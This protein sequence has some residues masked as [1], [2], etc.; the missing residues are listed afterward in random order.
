MKER[1]NFQMLMAHSSSY[2]S[3][4]PTLKFYTINKLVKFA[5]FEMS[6]NT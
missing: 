5:D 1:N 2:C 4:N 3:V 6:N